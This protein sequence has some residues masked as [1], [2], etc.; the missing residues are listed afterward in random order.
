MKKQYIKVEEKLPEENQ[1][2]SFVVQYNGYLGYHFGIFSEK[3]FLG[4]TSSGYAPL[5][6][7]KV[8]EWRPIIKEN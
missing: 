6:E 4:F 2:V 1:E 3:M 8:I 7:G 5:T